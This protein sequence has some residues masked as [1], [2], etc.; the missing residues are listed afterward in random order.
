MIFAAAQRAESGKRIGLF[1]SARGCR[2]M[3]CLCVN[4]PSQ[5]KIDSASPPL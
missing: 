3:M 1:D 4:H 5:C 2:I